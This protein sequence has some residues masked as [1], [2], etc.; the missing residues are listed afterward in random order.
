L[1]SSVRGGVLW[2]LKAGHAGAVFWKRVWKRKSRASCTRNLQ[3]EKKFGLQTNTIK[4][5]QNNKF[6]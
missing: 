1:F 6:F 5:F 2:A 3:R 4:L